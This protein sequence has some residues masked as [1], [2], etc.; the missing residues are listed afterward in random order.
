MHFSNIP[1]DS[2][3]LKLHSFGEPFSIFREQS[4]RLTQ[5]TLIPCN[6]QHA[7][8]FTAMSY[9]SR[10]FLCISIRILPLPL[11]LRADGLHFDLTEV[12]K[13]FA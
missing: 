3:W 11:K 9:F 5:A 4:I 8:N 10:H 7:T 13:I 6:T 12:H 2:I 1:V